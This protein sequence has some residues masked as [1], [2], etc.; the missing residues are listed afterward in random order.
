MQRGY[1]AWAPAAPVA[2]PPATDPD[3]L[4]ALREEA[5]SLRVAM[6]QIEARIQELAE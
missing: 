6:E 2:A 1:G 5:Q 3:E 4:S